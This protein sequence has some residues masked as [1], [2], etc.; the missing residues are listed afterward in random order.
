MYKQM[1]SEHSI[2]NTLV[3]PT[4]TETHTHSSNTKNA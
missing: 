4:H 2:Q 1:V 3:G